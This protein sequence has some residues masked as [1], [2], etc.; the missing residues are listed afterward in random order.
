MKV[1]IPLLFLLASGCS[2]TCIHPTSPV[3]ERTLD[4]ASF[5]GIEVGGAAQV[6]VEKGDIQQVKVTAQPEVIALL[7]TKV[8]GG[9]WDIST[10]K[11]WTSDKGLTIHITTPAAL[12][13]VEV[14]GSADVELGNVFSTDKTELSTSGSGSIS[15]AEI[16]AKALKV[17]ISGSGTITVRGTCTSMDADISGSGNLHAVDMAANA[18]DVDIAGSGKADVKAISTLNASVSGSGEVRYSGKPDLKSSI[19]GSGSVMPLP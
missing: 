12:T 4:V 5:T 7:E 16:N 8:D 14:S 11:C 1:I 6:T 17:D 10:S 19:S 3:E 18:V 15:A 9:V 13:S 2:I